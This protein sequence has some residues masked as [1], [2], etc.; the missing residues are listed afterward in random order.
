MRRRVKKVEPP[1]RRARLEIAEIGARGDGV[2]YEA[3]KAVFVPLTAPGDIVE[4]EICGA[5]GRVIEIVEKSPHRHPPPCPYFGRCGGCSQQHVDESF[6]RGW[7]RARVIEALARAGLS[8][9]SVDSLVATPAAS[10]RR[11]L[12]TVKKT[13]AGVAFGF[14]QART[15]NVVDLKTCDILHPMLLE[16]LGALRALCAAVAA[17]RFKLAVTLCNNGLDVD[18]QERRLEEPRGGDLFALTEAAK[19]AGCTRLSLNGAVI[20]A[21]EAPVV[22]LDGVA[23]TPPPGAFLQASAEGEAALIELV[24]VGVCDARKVCDL[25]AGCGSFAL[26]LAKTAIVFAVDSDAAAIAALAAAAANAQRAGAAINPPRTEARNL[27]E[28][29]LTAM[30]LEDFDAVVFDPPRAGAKAQ[31]E[32]L[33]QSRVPAVIGVSC[34][35]A[36]FARDAVILRGGGYA[37]EKVTP[38]DQFVYSAHVEL[39]GIFRRR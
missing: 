27:F 24:K 9:P 6:Y 11:A 34:N 1:A 20:V 29:P 33:A 10:R 32:A 35:P 26:P 21:F 12:F 30:E 16:K 31:A 3:G 22:A 17:P 37:L 18:I 7:K 38:V 23:V 14:N 15:T 28:R 36:T 4:A 8:E 2:A 5:R 39:V 25:F 13:G 19:D